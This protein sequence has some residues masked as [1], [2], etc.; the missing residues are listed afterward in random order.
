[1]DTNSSVV[2]AKGNGWGGWDKGDLTYS[3]RRFDF[4]RQAHN[5]IYRSCRN[6]P[7][8]YMTLLNNVTPNKF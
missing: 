5:T 8:T 2:A 1:M 3:D 4:G 7:E 6:P